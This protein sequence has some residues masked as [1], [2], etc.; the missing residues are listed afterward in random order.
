MKIKNQSKRL[1]VLNYQEGK[2]FRS[3]PIGAGET[4]ENKDLTKADISYYVNKGAIE[5][6]VETAEVVLVVLPDEVTAETLKALTVKTLRKYC[7]E[8]KIS[9]PSKTDEDGI[10]AIILA[11]LEP[12]E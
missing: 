8:N 6:V 11:S 1:I 5:E 2:K 12:K 3:L 10:I 4:V 7:K 9:I